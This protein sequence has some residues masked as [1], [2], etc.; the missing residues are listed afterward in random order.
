MELDKQSTA[1]TTHSSGTLG[2]WGQQGEGFLTDGDVAEA[3]SDQPFLVLIQLVLR[4]IQNAVGP[5]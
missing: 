4:F 1:Q 3:Q 2:T 5:Q